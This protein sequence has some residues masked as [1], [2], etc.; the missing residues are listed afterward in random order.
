MKIKTFYIR[1][2]NLFFRIIRKV[3]KTFIKFSTNS[4]PSSYPYISGDSFREIAQHVFDSIS[5]FEEKNVKENDIVFVGVEKIKE[6]FEI[7]H[8]NIKNKYKLITH[9][10]DI[11]I[12]EEFIKYI[13][14][15]IIVWFAQNV[16]V[17]HDKLV[18]IPIGLENKKYYNNGIPVIFNKIRK[19]LVRIDKKNKILFGFNVSTNPKE[20]SVARGILKNSDI[21]EE[22]NIKLEPPLYLNLLSKYK[23]V[24]SPPGNG[25]DCHRTWEAIYLKTIPIV[26]RSVMTEYF[27]SLGLPIILIDNWNE[28]LKMNDVYLENKYKEFKPL[29]DNKFL[30]FNNW[31]DKIK[32][33]E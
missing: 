30:L 22:I 7:K 3:N 20:R 11:N 12:D 31:M 10:G 24:A 5:N 18:P 28:I 16:E 13:D 23:F 2:I 6:F 25:I 26:K 33:Y 9:N 32:S 27:K 29:F 8:I 15:K 19:K 1:I 21:T 14:N 4:R 17:E